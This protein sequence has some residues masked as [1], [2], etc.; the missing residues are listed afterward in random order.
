M[1]RANDRP[2]N[3]W[4]DRELEGIDIV[5]FDFGLLIV[6]D[7][8]YR[9][10]EDIERRKDKDVGNNNVAAETLTIVSC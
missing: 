10:I 3:E 4:R 9:V 2:T 1:V 7:Q 8:I 6:G 5:D